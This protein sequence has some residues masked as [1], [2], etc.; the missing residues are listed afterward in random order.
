MLLLMFRI[1]RSLLHKLVAGDENSIVGAPA[2]HG[3]ESGIFSNV[4]RQ[5]PGLC[6]SPIDGVS[7]RHEAGMGEQ[8]SLTAF[9][10]KKF[11]FPPLTFL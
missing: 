10:L 9:I 5:L 11:M 2:V 7:R 6:S 8:C 1:C 4:L 3:G